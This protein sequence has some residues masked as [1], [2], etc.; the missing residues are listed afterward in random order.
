MFMNPSYYSRLHSQFGFIQFYN[1]LKALSSLL[2][3]KILRFHDNP[4]YIVRIESDKLLDSFQNIEANLII[5][6]SILNWIST[7]FKMIK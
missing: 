5:V 4:D 2:S 7:I 1:Y 3:N 6:H